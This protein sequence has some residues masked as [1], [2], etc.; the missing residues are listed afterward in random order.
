VSVV[1]GAR[2]AGPRGSVAAFTGLMTVP[3]AV[4]LALAALYT[5][6]GHLPGIDA[7]LRGVGAAAG[8]MVLATGFKMAEPLP[9]RRESWDFCS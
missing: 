1:V 8:G 3:L 7:L 6:F 5:R 2:F 4:V 9:G